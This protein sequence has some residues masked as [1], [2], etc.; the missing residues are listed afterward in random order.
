MLSASAGGHVV[1]VNF[2]EGDRVARGSVLVR[3]GTERLDNEIVKQRQTI[4]AAEE[5]LAR[6]D[7]LDDLLESQAVATRS[8][9]LAE[10]AQARAEVR[11]SWGGSPT[12]RSESFYEIHRPTRRSGARASTR[13]CCTTPWTGT[14]SSTTFGSMVQSAPPC[15][16]RFALNATTWSAEASR[17]SGR[18]RGRGIF[19]A[20]M[21][22]GF[23]NI[24]RKRRWRSRVSDCGK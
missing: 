19:G 20:P 1:E 12:T 18:G 2:R 5:E 11:L 14:G 13:T 21:A 17:R 8:K 15:S 16:G 3:L 22:S 23:R 9:S 6:F 10:L 4:R 24:S 7:R